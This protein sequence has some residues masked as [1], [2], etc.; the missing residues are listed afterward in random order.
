MHLDYVLL[1]IAAVAGT[2][3]ALAF[4]FRS[5][6]VP[7]AA[8]YIITGIIAGPSGLDLIRD[9]ELLRHLGELGVIMLMFFIG[10][11]VDLPRLIAGWRVAVL[12]TLLQ[13]LISVLICVAL[14]WAVG[15]DWR[16]GVVFGFLI[17]MSST[18]VVL[19]MLKD[20]Q[21]LDT[22]FGQNALGVLL[23][24]DMMIVPIVLLIGWISASEAPSWSGLA[25]Q[26]GGAIGVLALAGWLM[27]GVRWRIPQ[28]LVASE[29]KRILLG[30]VI[31][32]AAAALT[33][34]MGLSA[35]F[36]AFVAGLVLHDSDQARWIEEHLRSIYLLFVAIFFLSVG[37][38]VDLRFI[39]AH[40]AP[41]AAAT[42]AVFLLNSGI[43]AIVLRF[44]GERW[45]MAL[46]TGGLL[47]QIGEL[48][49]LIASK[50]LQ[51]GI[52]TEGMHQVAVAVIALTLVLSPVWYMLVRVLVRPDVQV[53]KDASMEARIALMLEDLKRSREG[54]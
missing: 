34:S 37:M 29:D 48:S 35:P 53:M 23:M 41:V 40:L 54:G 36:G 1:S 32:F 22:P 10:M 19:T 21:E 4:L 27:R 13:M 17:S 26:I 43:N 47:S 7:A 52:L 14:L 45:P 6:G 16:V 2:A 25:L 31:C 33:S 15:L 11:E 50:G 39:A 9:A 51:E 20:T 44:L 18:A 8:A 42:I 49:F 5:L 3:L 12:G 46:L 30:L 28:A 24:Q 38:L